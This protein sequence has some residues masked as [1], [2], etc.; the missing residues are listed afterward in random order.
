MYVT[1]NLR[2]EISPGRGTT[3]R[4]S[5]MI[6]EKMLMCQTLIIN[7]KSVLSYLKLRNTFLVT[8]VYYFKKTYDS[9]ERTSLI[10]ILKKLGLDNKAR[11][12]IQ[13]T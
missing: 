7:L 1:S 6:Y 12:I 9:I 3:G 13:Q 5:R 8:F 11:M 10:Q 4:I 2:K